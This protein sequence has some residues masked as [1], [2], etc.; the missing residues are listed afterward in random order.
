MIHKQHIITL[1][2]P[3]PHTNSFGA[4]LHQVIAKL[5]QVVAIPVGYQDENGFHLGIEP[6]EKEVKWPQAW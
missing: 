5:R 3:W 4:H 2:K 6:A 1:P